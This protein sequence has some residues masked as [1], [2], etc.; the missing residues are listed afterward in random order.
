MKK[1]CVLGLGYIG[2][3]TALLFANSD[4][5][6]V[7]VDIK[8]KVIESLKKGKTHF[9][10]KG[11]QEQLDNAIKAKNFIVSSDVEESDVFIVCV[12][13]PLDKET[14]YANLDLVANACN[15][16]APYL[17][18]GNIVIIESTISPGS[19]EGLFKKTLEKSGLKSGKDFHFAYCPE[20]AIPGNT[21]FEMTNNVRIIG[22]LTHK[23]AKLAKKLYLKI[24]SGDK[25]FLTDIKTAEVVKLLENTYRDLNI[26]L[27]NEFATLSEELKINV[28][29]AIK[30]ANYHPRVD[31]LKPGPGVG[32]HC[33]AID[34]WFLIESSFNAQ[35]VQMARKIN[36]NMPSYVILLTKQLIGDYKEFPTITVFGVAY[37]GNI[38]DTRETPAKKFIKL[39]KNIGW[40]IKL[41]DPLCKDFDYGE[42]LNLEEA[43]RDSDSIVVLTDH[44][45]FKDLDPQ[46]IGNLVRKKNILDAR[47]IL[48]HKKWED[49]GFKI[50]I[51]GN[52]KT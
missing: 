49:A 4:T 20:R 51:L 1:I 24:V 34:P 28:W 40:K 27:A 11:L 12:P 9:E 48:D 43:V 42:L 33:L 26:A 52:N 19:S 23:G 41:Y 22:A 25:I 46:E 6:V 31:I 39:A 16:I 2:L 17:R 15:M 18:K 8:E 44:D 21:L 7:G 3:P 13:T 38:G 35:I 50:K 36:N 29:E 45:V 47:N 30:L 37:K 32:G 5:K 14:H 10:E